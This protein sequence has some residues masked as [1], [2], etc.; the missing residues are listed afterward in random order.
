MIRRPS[1]L[2]A[3]GFEWGDAYLLSYSRDRWVALR[4]DTRR[5][6]IADTLRGWNTRSRL[7]TGTSRSPATA[8]RR[9]S[10]L[11]EPPR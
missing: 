5:F 6:L 2:E 4:R 10:G 11:P 8:I 9:D 7:T 3:L 1:A